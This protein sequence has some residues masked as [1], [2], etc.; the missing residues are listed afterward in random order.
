MVKIWSANS[1]KSR[2]RH[3]RTVTDVTKDSFLC[4]QEME[5]NRTG[6]AD[7]GKEE[8]EDRCIF[9]RISSRRRNVVSF[10]NKRIEEEHVFTMILLIY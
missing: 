2:R 7:S 3:S 5:L 1:Q 4:R 6:I 9:K 8:N 10:I